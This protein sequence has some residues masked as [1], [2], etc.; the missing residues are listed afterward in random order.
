MIFLTQVRRHLQGSAIFAL[1]FV[2]LLGAAVPAQAAST[3]TSTIEKPHLDAGMRLL[4]IRPA[5]F[6]DLAGSVG[7]PE[8][9]GNLLLWGAGGTLSPGLLRVQVSA[10]NGGL[11]A[12]KAS[13]SSAW[14][15]NLG[16]L[17]LEQRYPLGQF[18]VTAGFSFEMGELRGAFD[19][20]ASVNRVLAQLYGMGVNIGGRWPAQTPL[21]FF[22]R[23]GYLWLGGSGEWKGPLAASKN[24][25]STSFDLGGPN[26]TVQ[27]ELSF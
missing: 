5:V 13:K 3:T 14:D 8:T 23:A 15:L 16:A 27:V 26:L 21:G 6:D 7:F 10:Y 24:L 18:T 4:V 2:L 11:S 12:R 19:D 22:A 1:P 9:G 20:G 25:G 17:T